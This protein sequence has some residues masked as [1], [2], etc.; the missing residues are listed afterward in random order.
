MNDQLLDINQNQHREFIENQL[1]VL[2]RPSSS[3]IKAL[4]EKG[5]EVNHADSL[6]KQVEYELLR[7]KA[8]KDVWIGGAWL[9]GGAAIWIGTY[10]A[11]AS[12]GGSYYMTWGAVV[13]GGI[14]FVK[15]IYNY[16]SIEKPS[17]VN[18]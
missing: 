14:Q 7:K 8:R 1:V 17:D 13:F 16:V 3:V 12:N 4:I 11:A 15:G 2:E 10:V 6:V 18:F 5:V 9:V